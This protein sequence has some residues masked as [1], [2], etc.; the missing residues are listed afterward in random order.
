MSIVHYNNIYNS[1]SEAEIN[2][3]NIKNSVTPYEVFVKNAIKSLKNKT[4]IKAKWKKIGGKKVQLHLVGQRDF[5]K[6]AIIY[7]I[8]P[9][10]KNLD[11]GVFEVINGKNDFW[12][13]DEPIKFIS[14]KDRK[15]ENVLPKRSFENGKEIATF[16]MEDYSFIV[17]GEE[18]VLDNE[19]DRITIKP[20]WFGEETITPKIIVQ[21]DEQLEFKLEDDG[22]IKIYDLNPELPIYIDGEK[23]RFK[24]IGG[25]N[26]QYD[27]K[28]I[29]KFNGETYILSREKPILEDAKLIKEVPNLPFDEFVYV[30]Q[31]NNDS[32]NYNNDE[33]IRFKFKSIDYKESMRF[34]VDTSLKHISKRMKYKDLEFEVEEIKEDN[35]DKEFFR[36][37]LEEVG[38]IKDDIVSA[39]PL[40]YFF[41]DNVEIY[42]ETSNGKRRFEI[43]PR[44]SNNTEFSFI[45]AEKTKGKASQNNK[46]GTFPKGDFLKLS[47][48]T[49]QLEK[50]LETLNIFIN[51]PLSEHRSLLNLFQPLKDVKWLTPNIERLEDC[52]WLV[53][54]DLERNGCD[55]QRKFVEQAMS[56]PDFMLLEGPPGSGKTTAIL[57]LICQLIK[58][59]KRILLCGSTHV[60]IDNVLERLKEMEYFKDILPVRIGDEKRIS[61]SVQDFQINN[62]ENSSGFNKEL[63]LDS[64]NL[65]CATTMGILQHPNFKVNREDKKRKNG[66]AMRDHS[67]YPEF[68]YLIIDESS[69]TTFNEFLIPALFAKKWILVGDVKQLSPFTDRDVIESN[70]K[71]LSIDNKPLSTELQDVCFLLKELCF[72]REIRDLKFLVAMNKKE[73]PH[74]INEINNRN[75]NKKY[76]IIDN[77]VQNKR[78]LSSDNFSIKNSSEVMDEALYFNYQYDGIFIESSLIKELEDY[79]PIDFLLIRNANSTPLSIR[80]RQ[81]YDKDLMERYSYKPYRVKRKYLGL[82]IPLIINNHLKEKNW[83]S[84]ISWMMIREFELKGLHGK[85]R[86][87][88]KYFQREIESL[89]PTSKR[90]REKVEEGLFMLKQVALPSILESLQRGINKRERRFS[91]TTLTEGFTNIR[92]GNLNDR[93][94]ALKYQHRMHPEISK[95]PRELFYS[96]EALN[97]SK[98]LEREW[99]YN[100]YPSR[101]IWINHNTKQHGSSNR[102]EIEIIREELEQLRNWRSKNPNNEPLTIGILSF[103][104]K[105]ERELRGMLRDYCS[106]FSKRHQKNKMS[107][108]Y[109]ENRSE[110]IMI[111]IKLYTVDKFQGQEADVIFLSMVNTHK[112]GFMDNP[113]RLNVAITRA[114]YQ[115]I[116]VGK[117]NYYKLDSKSEELNKI[118]EKTIE[119]KGDIQWK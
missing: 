3:K 68:D 113:N 97:D 82:D 115:M 76:L 37:Q 90:E 95:V 9:I 6:V 119:F 91:T 66:I 51:K 32:K 14:K 50:Q 26:L 43:L 21:S 18:Y 80:L 70:V 10:S 13:G 44:T 56:T 114:K 49:Y 45:L 64:A 40:E 78:N 99:S 88:L 46:N 59:N 102:K 118:A 87:S 111:N 77:T 83:A 54:K 106:K 57:E 53:L 67:I 58:K 103:Y 116:Y 16:K 1:A 79:I 47:L 81:N 5:Y 28:D 101:S 73:M 55:E 23:T 96:N 24:T 4:D 104:R 109:L 8:K 112:D 74:L 62:L 65:V 17:D 48:N 19:W 38:E 71:H 33:N 89:L 63:I 60:A 92:K 85:K 86:E 100:R 34:L 2:K 42:E 22:I 108:F 15:K 31:K 27:D 94:I 93:F 110:K 98:K 105:Q 7:R 25:Y 30:K 75:F 117:R 69:K 52:E 84:E 35:N 36:V 41:D 29:F 20:L 61:E 11:E 39:S 12:D 107:Q 72:N